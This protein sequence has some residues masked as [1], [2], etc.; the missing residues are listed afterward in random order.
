MASHHQRCRRWVRPRRGKARQRFRPYEH[1]GANP[2][3]EWNHHHRIQTWRRNN[4]SCSC[5][6]QFKGSFSAGSQLTGQIQPGSEHSFSPINERPNVPHR[7]FRQCLSPA[8]DQPFLARNST[9][10]QCRPFWLT[11]PR[12]VPVESPPLLCLVP[13]R[14]LRILNRQQHGGVLSWHP[15]PFL[16]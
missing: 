10:H 13:T 3:G 11:R 16:R 7:F 12:D 8:P 15:E 1:A 4:Y 6:F 5:P 9:E 14:Q 2:A